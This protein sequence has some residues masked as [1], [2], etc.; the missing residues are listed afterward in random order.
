MQ[1]S[2]CPSQLP[3]FTFSWPPWKVTRQHACPSNF[4]HS[5]PRL[6]RTW[7]LLWRLGG[8]ESREQIHLGP[9]LNL[10]TRR[11][12]GP[13]WRIPIPACIP[14]ILVIWLHHPSLVHSHRGMLHTNRV[15]GVYYPGHAIWFVDLTP[16]LQVLPSS[17]QCNI[18]DAVSFHTRRPFPSPPR[19]PT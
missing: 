18:V 4:K 5:N 11:A 15:V 19:K 12:V 17:P 7:P 9:C 3:Y 16:E 14:H 10:V 8:I 1:P 6:W 13:F 2:L